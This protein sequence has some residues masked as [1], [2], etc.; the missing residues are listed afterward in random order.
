MPRSPLSARW[1]LLTFTYKQLLTDKRTLLSAADV[2]TTDGTEALLVDDSNFYEAVDADNDVVLEKYQL[3]PAR[4]G[5][6]LR[7][8]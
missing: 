8:S 1:G 2:R 7:S 4:R 5:S 3:P 6:R